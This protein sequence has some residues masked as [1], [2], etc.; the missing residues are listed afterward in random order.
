MSVYNPLLFHLRDPNEQFTIF[1]VV[2]YKSSVKNDGPV[3]PFN[4]YN[5]QARWSIWSAG[6]CLS[7]L[8]TEGE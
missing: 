3:V 8:K 5:G 2:I 6:R 4:G 1:R 7:G